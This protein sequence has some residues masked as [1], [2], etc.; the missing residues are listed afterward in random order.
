M[1]HTVYGYRA[2]ER[3]AGPH[4]VISNVFAQLVTHGFEA[5]REW[6][7]TVRD[8]KVLQSLSDAMLYDIGI[9]RADVSREVM[10]PFWEPID[11][12]ALN[13]QRRA[14]SRRVLIPRR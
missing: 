8:R 3:I 9:T 14:D 2:D 7:Q 6:R 10:R 1:T 4:T 11:Y 12:A 5:V 13:A